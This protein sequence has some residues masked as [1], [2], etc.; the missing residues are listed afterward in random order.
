M[1]NLTF[2]NGIDIPM[3]GLGVFLSKDGEDTKNA[4]KWALE[5]GY[6][7]IDTAMIYQNEASVGLSLKE[8]DVPREE[9][10]V[11]TKL[12][13][14]DIRSGNVREAFN[15][16]LELLQL[17]Y[18]DLY[19]I[20]WPATGYA[21]AW[22]EVEKLYN[23]GKIKA[24]GVSNFQKHHLEELLKT[25]TI[26]PMVNQIESNPVFTNQELI[27]YCQKQDIAIQAWSPFGGEGQAATLLGSQTLVDIAN[28][29]NKT[30]AQVIIRWNLQRD[31]I[32]LPKSVTK[33][34][35]IS[36]YDVFDFEL[37]QEELQ[38][39]SNM[40]TNKRTGPD[41]DNFNF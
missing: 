17:D 15:K 36:N 20:H 38:I 35:I 4:V 11:T 25:A 18:I 12:W 34:R 27:D 39:I 29:Y 37:T 6:R 3:V 31:V 28:K 24:I 33:E 1:K 26:K 40:N 7:H 16:S 41:P 32:V 21:K 10:F 2:T 23:E 5:A 22:A 30:T 13:N 9:I 8:T 14:E 19:L